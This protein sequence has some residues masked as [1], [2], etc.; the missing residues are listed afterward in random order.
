MN[1]KLKIWLLSI[2]IIAVGINLFMFLYIHIA[3]YYTKSLF[4][5]VQN[6]N[7]VYVYETYFHALNAP[8]YV[9]DLKDTAALVTYYQRLAKLDTATNY[10]NFPLK[11]N[12]TLY[13]PIYVYK[14][15]GQGSNIIQLIDFN[16]KCWGYFEGYY[17]KPTTHAAAPSDSLVKEKEAF[18]A[19]YNS[20]K[21]VQMVNRISK[22]ISVYGWYCND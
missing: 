21:R 15:F 2:V 1:R 22:K 11:M 5:E 3:Q 16:K 9:E 12:M 10:I 4:K 14:S 19:K 20:D 13:E 7:K 17:Y 18:I 6:N 8:F